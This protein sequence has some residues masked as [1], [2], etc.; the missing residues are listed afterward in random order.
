VVDG[1]GNVIVG[2]ANSVNGY[3]TVDLNSLKATLIPQRDK[4]TT[5]QILPTEILPSKEADQKASA[6]RCSAGK[7]T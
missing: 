5:L 2:S 6:V 4:S 7:Q 1:D 3:Y